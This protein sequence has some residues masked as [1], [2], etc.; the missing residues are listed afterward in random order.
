MGRRSFPKDGRIYLAKRLSARAV[1]GRIALGVSNVEARVL[2]ATLK[3]VKLRSRQAP[4]IEAQ[5][6]EVHMRWMDIGAVKDSIKTSIW[7]RVWSVLKLQL[8]ND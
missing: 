7:E 5:G 6:V 2:R 3:G 8:L 1:R 4:R